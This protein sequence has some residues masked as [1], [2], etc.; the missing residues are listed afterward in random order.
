V[1][2]VTSSPVAAVVQSLD[3]V[4]VKLEEPARSAQRNGTGPDTTARGMRVYHWLTRM[5]SRGEQVT[6]H[7]YVR[8]ELWFSR[9]II[10][11]NAYGM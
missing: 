7:D 10:R 6:L 9:D 5:T 2:Y 4:E 11:G 8:H 3:D 1:R